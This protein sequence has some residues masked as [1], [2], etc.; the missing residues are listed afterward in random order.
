MLP[1]AEEATADDDIVVLG[2]RS[3]AIQTSSPTGINDDEIT[4]TQETTDEGIE[5][6]K[7]SGP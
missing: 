3:S 1:D 7:S 6:K 2:V 4:N 5:G